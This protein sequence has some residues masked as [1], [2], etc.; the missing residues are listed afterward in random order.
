MGLQKYQATLWTKTPTI[1]DKIILQH[2]HCI[3]MSLQKYQA[4]LLTKTPTIFD[5]IIL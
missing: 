2:I 3:V 4:T 1:I 5:K